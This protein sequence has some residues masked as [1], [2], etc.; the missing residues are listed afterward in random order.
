M[1]DVQTIFDYWHVP[2]HIKWM[3]EGKFD[4]GLLSEEQK[5]LRLQYAE[6]LKA[7]NEIEAFREGQFYD[8]HYYN[9]NEQYQGYSDKLYV[10]VRHTANQVML[11]AINLGNQNEKASIKIPEMAWGQFGLNSA[12]IKMIAK[13][14][15]TINKAATFDYKGESPLTLSL[16]PY[17]YQIVELTEVK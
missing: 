5:A 3:N 9:R 12:K 1:M 15:T 7:C 8:L 4:G 10:F 6:I 2:E 17:S 16:K 11:V 13:K 14:S